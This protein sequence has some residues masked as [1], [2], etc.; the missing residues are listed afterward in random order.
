MAR[1]VLSAPPGV[2][3]CLN[4]GHLCAAR[5]LASKPV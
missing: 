1:R 3:D 2:W 5:V 4:E